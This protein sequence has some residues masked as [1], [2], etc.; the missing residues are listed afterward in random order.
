MKFSVLTP[1]IEKPAGPRGTS[2][3]NGVIYLATNSRCHFHGHF[4]PFLVPPDEMYATANGKKLRRNGNTVAFF[5][6]WW[7][8]HHASRILLLLAA[9][10]RHLAEEKFHHL[11]CEL[12]SAERLGMTNYYSLISPPNSNVSLQRQKLN[13]NN[14]AKQKHLP[15]AP[16]GSRRIK[17]KFGAW[18]DFPP[19]LGVRWG[20]TDKRFSQYK[21]R[22]SANRYISALHPSR[23]CV[24]SNCCVSLLCGQ[25]V[26]KSC[27]ISPPVD[28]FSPAPNNPL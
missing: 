23:L 26:H 7:R 20:Q 9:C 4:G 14:A 1:T 3:P 18:V 13:I 22:S 21:S 6:T 8:C 12:V 17:F 15:G 5:S 28:L 2:Q 27:S 10:S 19:K 25:V 16:L 11:S 24:V